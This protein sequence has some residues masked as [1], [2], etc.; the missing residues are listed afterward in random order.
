MQYPLCILRCNV[1]TAH[2]I[3]FAKG[4]RGVAVLGSVQ[5]E[6]GWGAARYGLVACGSSGS[7]KIVGLDDLIG[8]FQPC[9][10]MILWFTHPNNPHNHCMSLMFI[11]YH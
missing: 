11:A 2:I 5:E 10:S 4:G 6:S 3:Y 7:V 1:E 8:R 9:D